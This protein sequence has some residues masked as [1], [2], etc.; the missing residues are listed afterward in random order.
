[1]SQQL[2]FVHPLRVAIV[3]AGWR[4]DAAFA[5]HIGIQPANLNRVLTGRQ[6]SWP[7]LRRQCSEELDLPEGDLFPDSVE[8]RR[9]AS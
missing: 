2:R 5:R 8:R 4:S 7:K 6:P 3:A 9:V 1:V